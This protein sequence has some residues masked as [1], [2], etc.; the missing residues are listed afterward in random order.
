VKQLRGEEVPPYEYTLRTKD[1]RRI[2]CIL[3][4]AL[5]HYGGRNAVM[6]IITDITN[7]LR[8]ERLL[9]TLNAANLA[10]ERA[11]GPQEV[12]PAAGGELARLGL[13]SMVF[14]VEP[15]GTAVRLAYSSHDPRTVQAVQELFGGPVR[16]V[17]FDI[18][19]A[20]QIRRVIRERRVLLLDAQ[21]AIAQAL[22]APLKPRAA[23]IA[24]ALGT[25]WAIDVPLVAEEKV[26]GLLVVHAQDLDQQDLPAITAFANQ[27]AASWQKARLMQ[28]LERSL[29]ELQRT[30]GELVQA[31]KMEAIGRLAGGI[32][33]DFNN[34]LTAIGGY[35]QLLLERF[36]AADPGRADL[37]EIKKATGRAGALTRQLLAFS[38]KQVLQ[39]RVLDLNE[40]IRNME[41]MLR[42]LI[43]EHVEMETC[44]S[45]ELAWVRADPLQLEQVIMNLAI[46]GADAMPQGGRL[47]L[48]TD[49]VEL[50][51]GLEPAPTELRQGAYVLL[52]GSD[53]GVGMDPATQGRLF[54]PFFTTK[55]PGKGTGLGLSTVYGIVAQSGGCVQAY[56]RQGYGSSFKVYLPRVSDCPAAPADPAPPGLTP[57]A[58]A[59]ATA[60]A[61]ARDPSRPPPSEE[62]PR[63]GETVL[64]VEEEE[65][66]R[67]LM[68]KALAG[69]GYTVL[70]AERPEQA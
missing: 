8:S 55:P 4:S 47:V 28:D 61:T 14:L 49:N 5:L 17:A 35:T 70:E 66:P 26:I 20:E 33:H 30:Q 1:G 31:Q 3:N 65:V 29:R 53:N 32:A 59:P 19:G 69:C 23:E 13:N 22:P 24:Q 58:A 52:A 25:R 16:D 57:A 27:I 9:A 6:G 38:R 11:A 21:E 39:P 7:R 10:M 44:L 15:E 41:T 67:D 51:A 37:E 45:P 54:E 46:N 64:L 12:F 50:E 18:D 40:V 63:G 2:D 62:G 56:S 68:R 42:R 48:E 43:G 36:Q 60:A 34:L